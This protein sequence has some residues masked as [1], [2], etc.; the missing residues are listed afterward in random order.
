MTTGALFDVLVE[1]GLWERSGF[2]GGR[3]MGGLA[4]FVC[5]YLKATRVVSSLKGLMRAAG[6]PLERKLL[7]FEG[8]MA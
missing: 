3:G 2:R 7:D 6:L 1:E 8:A 4:C 5:S